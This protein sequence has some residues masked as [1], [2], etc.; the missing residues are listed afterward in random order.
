MDGLGLTSVFDGLVWMSFV[1]YDFILVYWSQ[2]SQVRFGCW[3]WKRLLDKE[4]I[5]FW[6][7]LVSSRLTVSAWLNPSSIPACLYFCWNFLV[8]LY[9][10]YSCSDIKIFEGFIIKQNNIQTM[11]NLTFSGVIVSFY[12]IS[13]LVSAHS[14]VSSQA[15][16]KLK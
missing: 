7:W 2:P 16:Q 4:Q 3:K 15:K 10:W 1:W 13:S 8:N 6:T 5:V 9:F 12:S 14:T 11:V